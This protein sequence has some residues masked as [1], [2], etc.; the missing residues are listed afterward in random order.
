MLIGM[1]K[2]MPM[3]P[4][5]WEKI[6][7]LMPMTSPLRFKSG[8]P[9]LPGLMEASVWMKFSYVATPTSERP[10]ALITPTVTVWSSPK[11]LP[12]AMAHSPTRSASEFPRVAIVSSWSG[13][14]RITARSVLG[15]VPRI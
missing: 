9:E 1:A 10:V 11:G 13:W 14:K 12:M 6:A 2:P 7:V 5:L 4:P 3:D 8:P 15:S